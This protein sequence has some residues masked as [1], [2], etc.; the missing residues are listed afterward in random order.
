[1][2]KAEL[3]AALRSI[4]TGGSPWN[5]D[6]DVASAASGAAHAIHSRLTGSSDPLTWSVQ[7]AGVVAPSGQ[8]YRLEA[9]AKAME[10]KK[11]G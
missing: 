6:V 1:M 4:V 2:T 7:T 3:V 5:T 9:V 10:M 11:R 8:V